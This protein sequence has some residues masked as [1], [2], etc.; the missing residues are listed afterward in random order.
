MFKKVL[1]LG[2]VVVLSLTALIGCGDVD[3]LEKEEDFDESR[4]A[5]VEVL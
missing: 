4:P 2:A 5:E 3:E 1:I